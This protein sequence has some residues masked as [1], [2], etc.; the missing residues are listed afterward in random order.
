[1]GSTVA[2]LV[3]LLPCLCRRSFTGL[4]WSIFVE[5]PVSSGAHV[6]DAVINMS[7]ILPKALQGPAVH[8][9]IKI[10]F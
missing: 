2:Y 10:C 5:H 9:G 8:L 6:Y 7:S 4:S 1:M 3:A